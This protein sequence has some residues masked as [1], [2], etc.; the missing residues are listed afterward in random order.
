MKL[1]ALAD[2]TKTPYPT[3]PA[4]IDLITLLKNR[5]H[6]NENQTPPPP[7]SLHRAATAAPTNRAA[8]M[9]VPREPPEFA[10]ALTSS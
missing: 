8:A 10:A 7:S 1:S 2:E 6:K 9:P 3:N 4:N 5:T